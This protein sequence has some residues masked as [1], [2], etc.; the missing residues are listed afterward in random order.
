MRLDHGLLNDTN[1][2]EVMDDMLKRLEN[3]LVKM[4]KNPF[5]SGDVLPVNHRGS[6]TVTW[7]ATSC[8]TGSHEPFLTVTNLPESSKFNNDTASNSTLMDQDH[9]LPD[10]AP[11]DTESEEQ[12]RMKR[13]QYCFMINVH[14]NTVVTRCSSIR[15]AKH[16]LPC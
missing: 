3:A 9:S 6:L 12:D 8:L 4:L 7:V 15:M 2:T 13:L 10:D 11:Q 16:W 5:H 1:I 14:A